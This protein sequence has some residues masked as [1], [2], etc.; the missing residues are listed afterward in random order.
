MRT[1]CRL[2]VCL[3]MYSPPHELL[4]SWTNLYETW[5]SYHGTWAHLNGVFYKSLSL[6]CASVSV[7][8]LSLIGNVPVATNRRIVFGVVFCVVRVI[9]ESRR[10]FLTR[11]SCLIIGYIVRSNFHQLPSVHLLPNIY[12]FINTY[13]LLSSISIT[14]CVLHM[15]RLVDFQIT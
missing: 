7:C 5:Y 9:K 11:T 2:Y 12:L 10:L 8:S 13:I 1:P 6:V 4:N 14:M 15:A 3:F